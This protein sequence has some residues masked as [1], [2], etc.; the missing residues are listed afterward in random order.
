MFA[1]SAVSYLP[2]SFKYS[3]LN[4]QVEPDPDYLDLK[5]IGT[6]IE[7]NFCF[8]SEKIDPFSQPPFFSIT[9]CKAKWRNTPASS[10][11][12]KHPLLT[13]KPNTRFTNRP[14]PPRGQRGRNIQASQS[15]PISWCLCLYL[16]IGKNFR[17]IDTDT[18]KLMSLALKE[19]NKLL[20]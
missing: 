16:Q 3:C 6:P 17:Y 4:H 10:R 7:T 8:F 11:A 5:P 2:T 1:A 20:G 9:N 12:P 15:A 19:S 14:A 13:S 18:I